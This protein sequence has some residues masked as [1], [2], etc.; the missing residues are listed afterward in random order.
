M[1]REHYIVLPGTANPALAEAVARLAGVP[2]GQCV[3]ERFPDGELSLA[4]LEPVRGKQVLIVQPTSPPV[5]EHLVELL[6]FADACRRAAAGRLI[7]VVPYF[8]YARADKRHGRREPI[9]A[10][11]VA[12]LMQSV[13]IDHVITVD[14]HARQIE[15]FFRVAVDSLTAVPTLHQALRRHLP[16][17][18]VVVSPDAGRVEM[19]TRYAQLLDTVVVVLHK[20]RQSG[21]RTEV[22]RIVG[23]VRDR[24]CLVVDDM[25]TTGGTIAKSIAALL[26]AGARPH[27]TVAA[28][29]GVLVDG[30]RANLDHEAVRRVLVTDTV[31]PAGKEW[32]KLEVVSVAPLIAA[33][34]QRFMADGSLGDLY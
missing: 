6:A 31:S 8:G 2:V 33:A 3:V 13:G 23:D 14:L 22:T 34:V 25:I 15:G 29:H 10:G 18:V 9:T 1:A 20:Q 5:D 28:T 4:I 12:H 11:M 16:E 27:I 24:A 17:D 30:W 32:S 19:A 21:S 26:D 7:A